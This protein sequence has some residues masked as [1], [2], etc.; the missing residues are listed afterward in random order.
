[1]LSTAKNTLEKELTVVAAAAYASK[2]N[3]VTTSGNWEQ[4]CMTSSIT[5]RAPFDLLDIHVQVRDSFGN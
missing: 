2:S 3:V 4:Q 5:R 1:M